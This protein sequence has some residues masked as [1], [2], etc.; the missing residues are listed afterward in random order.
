MECLVLGRTCHMFLECFF[1]D[2]DTSLLFR[3]SLTEVEDLTRTPSVALAR[4]DRSNEEL[5]KGRAVKASVLLLVSGAGGPFFCCCDVFF[6]VVFYNRNV[7][8]QSL[9]W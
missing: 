9:H 7:L 2:L 8:P 5:C 3:G 1:G 6:S 4:A